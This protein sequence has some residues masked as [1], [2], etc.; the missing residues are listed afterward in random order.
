MSKYFII[1]LFVSSFFFGQ[2]LN[3]INPKPSFRTGHKIKFPTPEKG[4]LLNKKELLS[5]SDLGE[6][7]TKVMD[8]NESRNIYFKGN[9]GFIY[10]DNGYLLRTDDLGN[11]WTSVDSLQNKDLVKMEILNDKIFTAT[12]DS[13]ITSDL[14]FGERISVKLPGYSIGDIDFISEDFWVMGTLTGKI[15]KTENAG[16][17]WDLKVSVDYTPS[18]YYFIYFVNSTLGFANRGHGEFL[19]TVDGGETWTKYEYFSR[20][21]YD[22]QFLDD[23]HGYV[24]GQGNTILKTLDGG[25]TWSSTTST[26]YGNSDLNGLYFTDL[27]TG[28]ATGE[29]GRILKTT[30]GGATWLPFAPFYDDISEFQIVGDNTM[31]VLIKNNTYMRSDD[32]GA[33]WTKL[34]S[35]NHYSYTSDFFFPSSQVGYSLGGGTSEGNSLFK[36]SNGGQVWTKLGTTNNDNSGGLYFFNDNHGLIGGENGTFETTNGGQTWVKLNSTPLRHLQFFDSQNGIASS[37]GYYSY[38]KIHKTND[39]GKTWTEIFNNFNDPVVEYHFVNQQV[40]YLSQNSGMK[41]TIDGG[42]T[43]QN[44]ASPSSIDVI[45]FY[46]PEIGFVHDD[47]NHIS[48]RTV[49]GGQSWMPMD[50]LD[51]LNDVQIKNGLV[52]FGGEFGQ[53]FSGDIQSL[54][55]GTPTT[56]LKEREISVYPNP[57]R[58]EVNFSSREPVTLI[59]IFNTTGQLMKQIQQPK[60][61]QLKINYPSGIYYLQF[62]LKSG[63]VTKKIIV[64]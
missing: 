42:Q 45:K 29:R 50:N 53:L 55:L 44:I 60:G 7:W 25:E 41:K 46:S 23:L 3:L 34:T 40:G 2:N 35:P 31:I 19:K 18:D 15:Y 20:E 52:Y 61:N 62:I 49:D 38:S 43:W 27:N 57:T 30:D 14:G 47:F 56:S 22:M 64:L 58:D 26:S 8:L 37:F 28:F 59:R 11:S 33:T 10:G 1:F 51:E 36:T 32:L 12:K 24:C 48:Y 21:L 13:I 4:F 63:A 9:T 17:S 5:T 6:T 16:V 54:S 39:G